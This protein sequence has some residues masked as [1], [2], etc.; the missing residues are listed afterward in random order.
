[1]SEPVL[2]VNLPDD[3]AT[4]ALGQRLAA[5]LPDPAGGAFIVYLA[6]PLGA[7]KSALARALLRALGITGTVRSPTYAL[8]EIYPAGRWT[9]VHL[10]LYRLAVPDELEQ[11]GPREWLEPAHLWLVEWPEK[12]AG[13]LPPADLTVELA[14]R[15]TG[16]TARLLVATPRGREAAAQLG[17]EHRL[18][19]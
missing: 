7:G 6:G 1:M 14:M 11:L 13:V 19:S 10:D 5:A 4:A 8:S 17:R 15:G 18:G 12:G 9:C 2:E 16:R 3:A